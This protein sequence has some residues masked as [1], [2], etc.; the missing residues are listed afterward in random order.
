MMYRSSVG[1]AEVPITLALTPY[2]GYELLTV[3]A[4][5]EITPDYQNRGWCIQWDNGDLYGAHCE[6]LEGQYARQKHYYDIKNLPAGDYVIQAEVIKVAGRS[7]TPIQN[8][9]VIDTPFR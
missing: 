8:V 4:N 2:N 1:G 7:V 9:H 3:H 6:Q 5:I